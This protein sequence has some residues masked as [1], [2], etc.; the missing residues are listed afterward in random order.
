M[1]SLLFIL[2]PFTGLSFM[3]DPSDEGAS[4]DVS[5]REFFIIDQSKELLWPFLRD[6]LQVFIY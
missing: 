1:D 5:V 4:Y 3:L 6:L 2:L